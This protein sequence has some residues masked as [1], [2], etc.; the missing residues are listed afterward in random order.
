MR[1]LLV[2]VALVALVA[3]SG[4]DDEGSATTTVAV[5]P[6]GTHIA[7]TSTAFAGATT[8]VSTPVTE[9]RYL[10]AVRVGSHEGFDRVVFE[11]ESGV[12]G[13]AVKYV[14]RPITEDGSGNQVDVDGAA[15]LSVRMEAASGADLSGGD[16]RQTY[17]GPKRIEGP[18]Q[19]VAEVV[20]T[21][22]FEAVLNWV[23]G[24]KSKAAFHAYTSEGNKLIVDVASG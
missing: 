1:R 16:L 15:V 5:G 24:V 10:K 4:D 11:F 6:T 12:P 8:P 23:L 9:Y 3:C 2:A 21:G 13:Y 18:G 22:D 20:R 17:A 19:A 14:D 7:T